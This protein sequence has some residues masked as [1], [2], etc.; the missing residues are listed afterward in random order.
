V[1]YVTVPPLLSVPVP[2]VVDPSSKVTVP[3]GVPALD[4]TVAVK[5]TEAP[6]VDGFR[7]EVS[8]V[9]VEAG[10]TI[11]VTTGEALAL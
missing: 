2:S 3:E 11:W 5:V 4:V 8:E 1:A 7:E 6:K 9:E 10:L